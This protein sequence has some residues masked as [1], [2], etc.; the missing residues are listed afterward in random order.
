MSDIL[1]YI[2]DKAEVA[3]RYALRR[4]SYRADVHGITENAPAD[5]RVV[6]PPSELLNDRRESSRNDSLLKHCLIR[7]R[8]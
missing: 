6:A 3:R 2:G 4:V 7:T 8:G 5:P 1:P